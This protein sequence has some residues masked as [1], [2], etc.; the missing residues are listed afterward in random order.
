MTSPQ[1]IRIAAALI[2]NHRGEMLVVRK[3]ATSVFIQPGGKIEPGESPEDALKRELQEELGCAPISTQFCGRYSAPAV[4]EA[5][6]T[7]EADFFFVTLAA[8]Q[9][10]VPTAEIVEA[11]WIDPAKPI[12][13]ELAPLT[14][15]HA[16]PLAA[17]RKGRE[18]T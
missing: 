18:S 7:V 6:H 12:E 3:R 17:S 14:S 9:Q 5:N 15:V 8:Q 13:I 11:K 1:V 2:L 10:I 4:H 16:V